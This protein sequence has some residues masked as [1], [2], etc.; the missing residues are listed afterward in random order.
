MEELIASVQQS[1]CLVVY[2]DDETHKVT[3]LPE[4]PINFIDAYYW[5]SQ[6]VC[7]EIETARKA[8]ITIISVV[9]SDKFVERK[10]IEQYQVTPSNVSYLRR[11]T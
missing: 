5:Q 7:A 9:N 6:W 8:N 3:Q 4:I 11:Q 2:L 1:C 10:L